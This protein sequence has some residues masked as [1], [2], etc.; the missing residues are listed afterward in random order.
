MTN[1]ETRHTRWSVEHCSAPKNLPETRGA[2]LRAPGNGG[3]TWMDADAKNRK[4]LQ[5]TGECG[6]N[7]SFLDCYADA[8]TWI[9][10]VWDEWIKFSSEW[11][12][13]GTND[14]E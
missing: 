1:S 12:R 4:K 13:M 7:T 11:A 9:S 8:G 10:G 6:A 3:L 5:K 2:M 14:I